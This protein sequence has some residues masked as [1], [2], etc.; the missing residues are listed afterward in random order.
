MER[1]FQGTT[2]MGAG[3]DAKQG[4]VSLLQDQEQLRKGLEDLMRERLP[5]GDADLLLQQLFTENIEQDSWLNN[6]KKPVKTTRQVSNHHQVYNFLG[7]RAERSGQIQR[8]YFNQTIS[9]RSRATGRSP[10]AQGHPNGSLK[11]A[12]Q[13]V[14]AVTP[15]KDE[16]VEIFQDVNFMRDLGPLSRRLNVMSKEFK[17]E[18]YR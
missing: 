18:N 7:E 10:E 3:K 6:Y 2:H 12:Q 15:I 1:L 17:G 8:E 16:Q 13:Y 5:K 9:G 11:D 14:A 4:Q